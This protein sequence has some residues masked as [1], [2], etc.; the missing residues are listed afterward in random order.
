MLGCDSRIQISTVF[1]ECT[2]D[3]DDHKPELMTN[4]L[5]SWNLAQDKIEQAKK[6]QKQQDHC[7]TSEMA[8]SLQHGDCV[9]VYMYMPAE[10]QGEWKL[11]WPFHGPYR[12]LNVTPTKVEMQLVN[13]P[14]DESILVSLDRAHH[15]YPEQSDFIRSGWR[16]ECS[17]CGMRSDVVTTVQI[18]SPVQCGP[19]THPMSHCTL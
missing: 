2:V 17:K 16:K 8:L 14:T 13:D 10:T 3:I 6:H 18:I 4:L 19:V 11:A 1:T 15:Q 12:V 5:H 9:M 7:T